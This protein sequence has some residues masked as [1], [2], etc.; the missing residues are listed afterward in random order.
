MYV[1]YISFQNNSKR[2]WKGEY[3]FDKNDKNKVAPKHLF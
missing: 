3:T 2:K 1:Q